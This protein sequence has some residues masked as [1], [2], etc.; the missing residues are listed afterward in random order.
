MATPYGD[1]DAFLNIGETA[2]GSRYGAT[3]A[4]NPALFALG[5]GPSCRII[6]MRRQR[7]VGT[8]ANLLLW[9]I[10]GEEI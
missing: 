6:P 8:L 9:S 7:S 4:H 5:C 10:T 1:N 3:V 2:L